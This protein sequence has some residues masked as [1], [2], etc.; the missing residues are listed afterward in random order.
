MVARF[1]TR[2]TLSWVGGKYP[3]RL[4]EDLAYSSDVLGLIRVPAGYCTDFA[5]V[6]RIPGI[7]WAAGG[8]A[9]LPAIVHDHLYDCWTDRIEREMADR[10]F[11]EAMI[12][13]GDPK[14]GFVRWAMYA[15]VRLGGGAPWRRDSRHKCIGCSADNC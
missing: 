15:A 12:A 7:Y 11:R 9:T 14:S 2:P 10:V 4:D 8:K 5:S 1:V 3:W 13:S 6:P